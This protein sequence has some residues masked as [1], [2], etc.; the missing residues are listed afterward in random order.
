MVCTFFGNRD[1]L[2]TVRDELQSVIRRLIENHDVTHFYVGNHGGFD[3]I[4]IGVLQK[5]KSEH[6][7]I[8]YSVVLAYMNSRDTQYYDNTVYP[9]GLEVTPPRY[10]VVK[11]NRWMIDKSDYVIT[12][13]RSRG[14]AS[15]ARDYANRK[16]KTVIDI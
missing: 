1:T 10:A 11:R 3:R 5:L 16:G 12:C 7:H 9:E 4:V 14:G 8:K 2:E 13:I 15:S 6:P